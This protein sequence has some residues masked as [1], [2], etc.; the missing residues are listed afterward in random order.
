LFRSNWLRGRPIRL[1]GIRTT[2]LESSAAQPELLPTDQRR[3]WERAMAAADRLRDKYGD[4]AIS[5]GTAMNTRFRER[6]HENPPEKQ[7]FTADDA[8]T[9]KK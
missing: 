1:L 6:V 9:A 4:T 2:S 3:Q 5:L 7:P 8:K